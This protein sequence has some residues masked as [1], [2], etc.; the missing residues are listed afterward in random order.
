LLRQKGVLETGLENGHVTTLAPTDRDTDRVLVFLPDGPDAHLV[1]QVLEEAGLPCERCGDIEALIQG[2]DSGAGLAI[3]AEEVLSQP[4]VQ[5][6]VEALHRQP[7][8]SDFP[9][10]VLFNSGGQTTQTSR[11]MLAILEPLGNVSVLERPVR[12]MSLLSAVQAALR[13]RRRQYL[14]RD[15]LDQQEAALTQRDEFLAMLAHELRNPLAVIRNATLILDEMGLLHGSLAAEQRGIIDRQAHLLSR[16][17]DDVQDV[18]RA[19]SGKLVLQPRSV[20]L[21]EVVRSCR[22]ELEPVARAQKQHLQLAV[23]TESVWVEGSPERLRQVVTHLLR[24]AIQHTPQ[25]GRIWLTLGT[26]DGQAVVRVRDTGRGIEYERLSHLFEL[27]KRPRHSAEVLPGGLGIGLPM[28]RALTEMHAGSVTAASRGPDQGSEFTI[29]VPLRTAPVADHPDSVPEEPPATTRR[30]ILLV[31]DNPDGRETLRLLLQLEGHHVDVA[32]DGPQGVKKA[33]TTR[34]DVALIDLGL[35][36]LD[37][38]EVARQVRSALG[39]RVHLIAL[40]GYGE[41]HDRRRALEAGFHTHLVKPVDPGVLRKVL[42]ANC[43]VG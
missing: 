17:V 39:D 31:E 19:V 5:R 6:L 26:E 8:W 18:H 7:R 29:R 34:P 15:L 25:G 23:S 3:L 2:I 20:D 28:V 13:A 33:L 12:V 35:P 16:L 30:R 21:V 37:G 36:V 32:E 40:T 1:A 42:A 11:R 4:A 38:Y 22:E 24:N 14:L 43:R 41:P 9:L 10:V 27:F